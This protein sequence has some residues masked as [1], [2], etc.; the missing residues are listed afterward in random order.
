MIIMIWCML[1]SCQN[2]LM[3]A[4]LSMHFRPRAPVPELAIG[5]T[6]VSQSSTHFPSRRYFAFSQLMQVVTSCLKEPLECFDSLT[7]A[8]VQ[9]LQFVSH[10]TQEGPLAAPS[11]AIRPSPHLLFSTHSLEQVII[12]YDVIYKVR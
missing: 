8:C 12:T 6:C 3:S 4:S 10:P 1:Y 11:T 9:D 7:P 5:G 2:T